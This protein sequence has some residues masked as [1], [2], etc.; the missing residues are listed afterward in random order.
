MPK[1]Q[2]SMP[3][4]TP[5][6]RPGVLV[7]A[8]NPR[9]LGGRGWG[10]RHSESPSYIYS[11]LEDSLGYMLKKKK[12]N[13]SWIPWVLDLH[14]WRF[15]C[16]KPRFNDFAKLQECR[17]ALGGVRKVRMPFLILWRPWWSL[18]WCKEEWKSNHTCL[19]S[20]ME[21]LLT[22]RKVV[23]CANCSG[24][25]MLTPAGRHPLCQSFFLWEFNLDP[26]YS[27]A[28]ITQGC[29]QRVVEIWDYRYTKRIF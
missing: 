3:S 28:L 20:S 17:L 22:L 16:L 6:P 24:G 14:L 11:Q 21:P 29:P 4:T 13:L 18:P 19:C 27:C 23:L 12:D 7:H 1:A 5:M 8:C 10:I 26:F 9:D 2:G 15:S 25:H